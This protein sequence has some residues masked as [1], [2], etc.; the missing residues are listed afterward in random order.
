MEQPALI[1]IIVL[2]SISVG[3][4]T[5]AIIAYAKHRDIEREIWREAEKHFRARLDQARK[6][7]QPCDP[8]AG[9]M[10]R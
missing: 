7:E 6:D 3:Y 9:D 8:L 2:A 10:N 4:W 1:L 5:A